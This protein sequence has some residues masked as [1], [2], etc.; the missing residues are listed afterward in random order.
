MRPSSSARSPPPPVSPD[1]WK[2]WTASSV[3]QSPT[4]TRCSPP[5]RPPKSSTGRNSFSSSSW[6][7]RP[8]RSAGRSRWPP[9]MRSPSRE[10]RSK[11]CP[12][13]SRS[14]TISRRPWRSGS[15]RPGCTRP[16]TRPVTW[17]HRCSPRWWR[18][19]P[20]NSTSTSYAKPRNGA[21]TTSTAGGCEPMPSD[22]E[23]LEVFRLGEAAGVE[24][25]VRE[26]GDRLAAA[27]VGASRFREVLALTDRSR[28]VQTSGAT[29]LHAG[30]AKSVLGDP[31][32]ALDDY[33]QALPICREVGDRAGEA[34]TLTNI[35]A[36]YDGRGDG[37]SALR[38]YQQ[39]LPI[40]REVGDRAG[41]AATL[42]NIGAVYDGRGD[43]G[44]ALRHY[45]QALPICREVGDR[46][47]EAATLTNIG[48]VY[49]GR[50][51][52]GSALR[53][54]QQALPICREV[55]DRAGEAAT[56]TNIGMVYA[57]RGDGDSALHHYQQALP[58]TRQVG[59]RAGEAITRY[60]I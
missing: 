19:C 22:V 40:C 39:A 27:W 59:D 35:G 23:L 16:P 60:S 52:G 46:A 29:L 28:R 43:G 33:R 48:A 51:D 26:V 21:P 54:Y 34:A 38:H 55:G 3:P 20:S 50:G 15:S 6:T 7:G 56:L 31:D 58:I 11:H 41:E 25:V 1:F 36:V 8:P 44:S 18:P 32:G 10:K 14:A 4:W 13:T 2:L 42:T 57:Q 12:P 45:Q 24:E 30:H 53:H 37:G 47:G 49:D 17:S 9:S 5:S